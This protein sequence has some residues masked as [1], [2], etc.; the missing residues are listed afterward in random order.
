[1]GGRRVKI[2]VVLLDILTMV[3]LSIGKPKEPLLDDRVLAVPQRK[4]PAEALLVVRDAG[5]AVFAP[6]VDARTRLIMREV[7]P[8]VTRLGIILAHCPP[9]PFREVRPPLLPRRFALRIGAHT[10][11]LGSA[12]HVG[13]RAQD[14]TRLSSC[15]WSLLWRTHSAAIN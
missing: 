9:L 14:I 11:L 2:I 6:L 15:H 13:M 10:R 8:R 3:P 7:V 1:M 5:N 4:R 12:R